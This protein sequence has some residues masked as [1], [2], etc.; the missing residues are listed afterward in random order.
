[1][2]SPIEQ[3]PIEQPSLQQLRDRYTAA[4]SI[5]ASLEAREARLD[6]L[7]KAVNLLRDEV[8]LARKTAEVEAAE[9]DE[10]AEEGFHRVF[11]RLTGRLE[12]RVQR[13]AHEAVVAAA[14]HAALEDELSSAIA[15]RE[16]A[17]DAVRDANVARSS[18]ATLKK[19]LK[20][21]VADDSTLAS[22]LQEI[23][24]LIAAVEA[25]RAVLQPLLR[26][27]SNATDDLQKA[28]KLVTTTQRLAA[29]DVATDANGHW[30]IRELKDAVAY[31]SRL[32][33]TLAS[34]QTEISGSTTQ[35]QFGYGLQNENG[36]YTWDAWLDGV[37]VDGMMYQAIS[38]LKKNLE[39]LVEPLATLQHDLL[40]RY[41]ALDVEMAALKQREFETLS[42]S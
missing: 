4:S 29:L 36:T 19:S 14:R 26:A 31:A 10:W 7:S 23:S 38:D 28:Q 42:K 37:L 16:E 25:R 13:E 3:F 21:A 27:C 1:M 2:Q 22:V 18:L 40:E 8:A 32:Q 5:A 20:S 35:V 24:T 34:L 39:A 11:A 33:R 17:R 9:A 30:K 6:Q 15:A 41:A 12:E